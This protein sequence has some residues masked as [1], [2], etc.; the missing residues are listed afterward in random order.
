MAGTFEPPIVE[1]A[2][3]SAI[4]EL[5]IQVPKATAIGEIEEAIE[6]LGKKLEEAGVNSDNWLAVVE[7]E[8]GEELKTTAWRWLGLK[9]VAETQEDDRVSD[10]SRREVLAFIFSGLRRDS[11]GLLTV[12]QRI[13]FDDGKSF[14]DHETIPDKIAR[15]SIAKERGLE[16][17]AQTA[18]IAARMLTSEVVEAIV[19]DENRVEPSMSIE[20][21]VGAR[22]EPKAS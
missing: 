7:G 12:A 9:S 1:A 13:G 3:Q 8:F 17:T 2:Y 21:F 10:E 11:S 22:H 16:F 5:L 19:G 15:T 18:F 20:E 6:D 4:A 14:T